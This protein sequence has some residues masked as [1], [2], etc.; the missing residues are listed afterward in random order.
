MDELL[1][2]NIEDMEIPLGIEVHA[3][4]YGLNVVYESNEPVSKTIKGHR[5]TKSNMDQTLT[6]SMHGKEPSRSSSP[7]PLNQTQLSLN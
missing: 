4:S 7:D 3:D 5:S 1:V 2:C 6:Q